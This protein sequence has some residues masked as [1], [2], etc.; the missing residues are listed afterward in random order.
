MAGVPGIGVMIRSLA[1]GGAEKQ[2]VLLAKALQAYHPTFL[3]ILDRQPQHPKHQEKIQQEGIQAVFLKGRVWNKLK[4]LIQLVRQQH[5]QYLFCFLPS[6]TIMATLAARLSGT[7]PVVYGGIRNDKIPW[8]KKLA[9]KWLHNYALDHSISNCHAG[10]SNLVKDG[11]NRDKFIV[12]HNALE[13]IPE[14]LQKEPSEAVRI[15]TVGRF[16][17]QKGFHRAL[18]IMQHLRDQRAV[19]NFVYTIIGYGKLEAEIRQM[20]VDLE[21]TSQVQLLVNPDN[22]L[23]ELSQSDIYLCTSSFEGLSNAVMEAMSCRLPVVATE[24]GD[25]D[26]LVIPQKNGYLHAVQDIPGMAGSI[27]TLIADFR[28]RTAYG[29]NSRQI[30]QEQFVFSAFQRK[31]LQLLNTETVSI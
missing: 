22:V 16:V 10:V 24:V 9:L 26:Y 2:S 6:D 5:I 31:Y 13:R 29:E 11:F 14:N 7:S 4:Q 27:A 8:R 12:I 23:A 30:I 21:L 28:L 15:V 20:I 1:N 25:N 3:I 19:T 18:R 17:A